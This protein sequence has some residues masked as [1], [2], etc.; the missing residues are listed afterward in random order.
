MIL[1]LYL[2]KNVIVKRF[3][4]LFVTYDCLKILDEMKINK[5]KPTVQTYVCLLNACAVEGRLDRVYASFHTFDFS[6]LE[7]L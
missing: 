6:L 3:F 4:C 1:S 7:W 2:R 5:E